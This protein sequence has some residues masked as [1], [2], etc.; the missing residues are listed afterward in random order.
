[1]Y[2]NRY[3][4]L[5][6]VLALAVWTPC[7]AWAASANPGKVKAQG[8]ASSHAT[9]A[10]KAPPLPPNASALPVPPKGWYTIHLDGNAI[11]VFRDRYGVPHVFAPT[12]PLAFR[13]QGYVI[14][15]DRFLQALKNREGA[16]GLRAEVDGARAV[17]FDRQMRLTGYTDKEL[18]A[19]VDALR[20]D[21]RSYIE[22]YTAGINDY[23]RKYAP[24]VKPWRTIDSAAMA[25]S[26]VS[27]FGDGGGEE[28]QVLNL[29]QA[30]KALKG[31]AV[32]NQMLHDVFPIDVSTAP[33]TDHSE[34]EKQAEQKTALRHAE[35]DAGKLAS[36]LAEEEDARAYA[37][38]HGLFSG[39]GSDAWVVSPKRSA[40]GHALLFGG[41]M[42]G[43]G[44][45]SVVACVQL[46]A[47][48]LNVIG[49]C[50]PGVP[51]V[52][53]G[54]NASL[55]WT[56][57]SGGMNQTDI[58]VEKLN[59]KNPHQYMHNGKWVNMQAYSMPISVRQKNGTETVEPFTQYRT[60]HGP[61]FKW[62]LAKNTAY[63]RASTQR[64]TETESLMAFLDFDRAHTFK[65]FET[66]VRHVHSSHNFF[67]ADL[68]GNIGY[69]LAGRFPVL[70][71]ECD[72]RLPKSGTGADDWTGQI[73]ATDLVHCV[74]P[75]EGWFGNWNNKPSIKTPCSVPEIFWGIKILDMLKA[76]NA[77]TWDYLLK[78][79]RENGE[80]DFLARYFKPYLLSV[81]KD[82]SKAPDDRLSKAVALLQQWPDKEV[83]GD[84]G[85][86]LFN[87]W[88]L[89]MMTDLLRPDFGPVVRRSL[90]SVNL[91]L[92]GAL[93]YR[94]LFPEK[95]GVKLEGDYLHGRDPKQL[96]FQ[97]FK[98]ALNTLEKKFGTD[99]KA[100]PYKRKPIKFGNL[101][102]AAGRSMGTYCMGV[103]LSSPMRAVDLNA[104]GQCALPASPHYSD[105]LP[106]LRDWK[107][108]DMV[109]MTSAS[110]R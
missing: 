58:F 107:Y 103:E 32:M 18:Q 92:F 94:V 41:P 26:L 27:R 21:L 48:G 90:N 20:P 24:K 62:D 4:A 34:E 39:W 25:V 57:T 13:A 53:I 38:A 11:R 91:W 16:R 61:V 33:T 7:L 82:H 101:G 63:S 47:P 95:S 97:A 28:L 77:V 80:A 59:P 88:F 75:K 9:S 78:I 86:L 35:F 98:E 84:A 96:A 3:L 72:P 56:T 2:R 108:R 36:A 93:T 55:A 49:M 76:N 1:M 83:N 51:G 73:V 44:T 6:V 85:A 46:V 70:P 14:M 109:F 52:L 37:R 8:G 110:P 68:K 23:M 60:V 87:E 69:W 65:E 64:N 99:M 54:H 15:E 67:A 22:A 30:V 42:M 79:N 12:I 71:K 66:A 5:V 29:L 105:Q 31:Q 74:N 17:N 50:F 89:N 81:L 43:W 45:P 102:T 40:S 19:Q 106:L 10:R 100:W 104:P